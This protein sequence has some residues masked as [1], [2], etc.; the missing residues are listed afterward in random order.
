MR[1]KMLGCLDDIP[2]KQIRRCV[3][4]PF[5]IPAL[6]LFA[7]LQTDPCGLFLPIV[8]V[9]PVPKQHGPTR[10]TMAIAFSPLI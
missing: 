10:N 2:L 4:I 6:K 9:C 1:R 3:V 8:K 5:F 7:D